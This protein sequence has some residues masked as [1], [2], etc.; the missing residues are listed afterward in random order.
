MLKKILVNNRL[1]PVP[2]PVL[3]L[4]QAMSWVE[5]TLVPAGSFV[6]R[7]VLDRETIEYDGGAVPQRLANVSLGE[8]SRLEVQLDSPASLATQ[9]L[10]TVHSLA[11]AILGTL[12]SIAVN[13]WQTRPADKI[14]ELISVN[15]DVGLVIDLIG[16]V[17]ELLLSATAAKLIDP[18]PVAGIGRL[19]QQNLASY[20]MARS[21]SDWKACAKVMLNRFEP[22]LKDLLV[23]SETLQIRVL[24]IQPQLALPTASGG[25]GTIG[26]VTPIKRADTSR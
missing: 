15:D 17:H 7:V 23:E 24:A 6:T 26:E 11:S 12:K 13:A 16:H 10:D 1:V 25:C 2:V 5:S 9:T 21:Q 22:L 19:L 20:N 8:K 14:P 4:A 18:G 3:T